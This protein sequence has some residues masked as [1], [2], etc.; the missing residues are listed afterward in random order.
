MYHHFATNK[1][2]APEQRGCHRQCYGCPDLLLIDD[3][4]RLSY[5][6]EENAYK[7]DR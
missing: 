3:T 7:V 2:F 1:I 4:R 5:A 6:Q